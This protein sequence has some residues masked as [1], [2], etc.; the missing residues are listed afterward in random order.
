MLR[1][2]MDLRRFLK[3]TVLLAFFIDW[4]FNRA[5]SAGGTGN[6]QVLSANRSLD[7]KLC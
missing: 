7:I 6:V 2:N 4:V 1:R 5:E 3:K